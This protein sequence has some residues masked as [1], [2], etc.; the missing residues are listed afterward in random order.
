MGLLFI[1]FETRRRL[2]GHR[3]ASL[4]EALPISGAAIVMRIRPRQI[5]LNCPRYVYRCRREG[6][7]G[8]VPD[9][10]GNAPVAEW[11]RLEF[12]QE[13]LPRADRESVAAIG[14][15][16]QGEYDTKVIKGKG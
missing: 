3:L 4:D 12:L 5:F 7:S 16:T 8:Y 1:D 13:D 2:R 15:I 9:A 10:R 6:S 14:T 11:K